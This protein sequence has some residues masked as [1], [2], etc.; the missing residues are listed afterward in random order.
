MIEQ[1]QEFFKEQ[2]DI[3]LLF[4]MEDIDYYIESTK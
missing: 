3:C 2:K 1:V 4:I